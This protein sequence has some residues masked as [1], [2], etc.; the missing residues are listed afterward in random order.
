MSFSA[1]ESDTNV[2]IFHEEKDMV[3]SL[4]AGSLYPKCSYREKGHQAEERN[5]KR[6]E[7]DYGSYTLKLG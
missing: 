7:T 2:D 6:N 4:G 3:A 5:K 1:E